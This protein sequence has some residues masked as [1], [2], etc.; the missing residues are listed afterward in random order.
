MAT[1]KLTAAYEAERGAARGDADLRRRRHQPLHR[2]EECRGAGAGLDGAPS[3]AGYLAAHLD[4]LGPGDYFALLA[5]LEMNAGQRARAAGDPRRRPR[6]QAGR[7]LPRV[8]AALP[9]LD[10]SGL[11]GRAEH[12]A[13][14]CRSPATTPSTCRCPGRSTPSASSRRRRRAAISRCW[15]SA[16]AGRC[17]STSGPDVAAG[18]ADAAGGD[19]RRRWTAPDQLTSQTF[20]PEVRP[21][22]GGRTGPGERGRRRIPAS[23]RARSAMRRTTASV[24]RGSRAV[25]PIT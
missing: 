15:R 24:Q 3:L 18:L 20:Q 21:P 7:D 8:R 17:A 12:A 4:R 10:G 16:A 25:R 23:P 14:S 1:R 6:R 22:M 13:C 11:Q 5:Y 19:A 9:A 2:R